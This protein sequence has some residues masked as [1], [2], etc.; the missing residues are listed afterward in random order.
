MKQACH[1]I[2]VKESLKANFHCKV[3]FFNINHPMDRN[4]LPFCNNSVTLEALKEWKS[5][6]ESCMD[7]IKCNNSVYSFHVNDFKHKRSKIDIGFTDPL[8][9]HHISS[10]SYDL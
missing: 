1:D 3:P 6:S 7:L 10:I 4:S 5:L 8:V 9:E 2:E